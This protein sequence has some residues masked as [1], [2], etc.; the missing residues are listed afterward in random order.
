M[1]E[2]PEKPW[3]KEVETLFDSLEIDPEK[4]LSSRGVKE[5]RGRY[6]PN[7]IKQKSRKSVWT[8]LLNQFES[9]IVLLLAA[10]MSYMR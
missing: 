10:V 7:Q 6:G 3:T 1:S 8:I 9:V 2:L 4:G 5:R